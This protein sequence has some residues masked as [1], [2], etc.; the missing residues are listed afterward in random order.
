MIKSLSIQN[1]QSHKDS[2]LEFDPGCNVIV[3]SSDSGK[4]AIL[5]ALKKL[6]DN[7]PSGDS[8]RSNWGGETKIEIFT[9]DTHIAWIKDK[10]AE[11]VLGDTHFKAFSTD[12]PKEI[13]D[14]LNLSDVNIQQQLDQ[15]FLLTETPGAVAHHFNKVA[16][17]DKIDLGLQNVQRWI[18]ELTS[19]I[20]KEATKD[21]PATGLIKQLTEQE[22]ALQ[23]YEYL[24]KMESEVEVLEDMEKALQAKESGKQRLEGLIED[25]QENQKEIV[26]FEEII[27]D[28]K[29]VNQ[30]LKLIE[31]KDKL[32]IEASKIDR[33][34]VKLNSVKFQIQEYEQVTLLEE[35]VKQVLKLIEEKDKLDKTRTGIEK[36]IKNILTVGREKSEEELNL[37]DYQETFDKEMP[38]ICPLCNQPIKKK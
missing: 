24:D 21:K 29:L 8:F 14:A 30:T 38:D 33:L 17:L 11:Y 35:K 19:A 10:E 37:K 12:V 27:S 16:R 1:F 22:T 34:I 3:G 32:D 6:K 15:P 18:N 20:G 9:D 5:R 25:Y 31:D 2:Y 36:I 26:S 7:R 4:T 28:E 23:A 13:Q